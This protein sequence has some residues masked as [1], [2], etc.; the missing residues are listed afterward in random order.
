MPRTSG[1][2]RTGSS[3]KSCLG[4][5]DRDLHAERLRSSANLAN[6]ARRSISAITGWISPASGVSPASAPTRDGAD[7][8]D[9]VASLSVGRAVEK[10]GYDILLRALALLPAD[11]HWR[12][13]HI[14]GG[15]NWPI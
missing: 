2:R 6:G 12:F 9:P 15:D 4:P 11:L 1:R 14:G 8:A 10:K 13:E 7:P 3:P 5:L